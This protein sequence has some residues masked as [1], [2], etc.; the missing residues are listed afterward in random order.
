[1]LQ[2]LRLKDHKQTIGVDLS[3]S[4]NDLYEQK[5]LENINK[6]YK[7]TGKCDNQKKF[8]DILDTAMVSTP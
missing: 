7:Q 4:N 3:L 2:S 8:K 6:L 5:C 1:M